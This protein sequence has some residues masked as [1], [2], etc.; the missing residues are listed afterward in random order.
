VARIRRLGSIDSSGPAL[1]DAYHGCDIF[2]LPSRHEPFGIVVLEAWSAGKPVV[3]ARVG[4]L[5]NLIRDGVNGFLSPG[6]DAG[7]MAEQIHKLAGSAELR[8]QLGRAGRELA[9]E[10]YTWEK[11][12][13]E[14]ERIYQAAEARCTGA[15]PQ[16]HGAL[17]PSAAK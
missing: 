17:I 7:A 14:T 2:V 9:I 12:A 6:A 5:R 8:S 1:P 11:I 13:D 3:A 4:G 10:N 15:H 16:R